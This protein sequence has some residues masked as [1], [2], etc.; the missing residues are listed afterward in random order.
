M[1]A[2]THQH[3][4]VNALTS[5]LALVQVLGSRHV[6]TMVVVTIR[7]SQSMFCTTIYFRKNSPVEVMHLR[8]IH[9]LHL[10]VCHDCKCGIESKMKMYRK[11]MG[12]RTRYS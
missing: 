8:V 10:I 2:S 6:H 7:L 4:F 12:G 11:I 1:I 5:V 3:F 9:S